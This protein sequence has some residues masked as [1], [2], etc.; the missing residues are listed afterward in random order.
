MQLG[1]LTETTRKQQEG[2]EVTLYLHRLIRN[3]NLRH[4]LES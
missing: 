4:S 1:K 2:W 3:L